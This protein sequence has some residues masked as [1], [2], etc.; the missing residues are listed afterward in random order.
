[1]VAEKMDGGLH[2]VGQRLNGRIRCRTDIEFRETDARIGGDIELYAV[3]AVD[4][5]ACEILRRGQRQRRE[6]SQADDLHVRMAHGAAGIRS[7]VFEEQSGFVLLAAAHSEPMLEPKAQQ[8]VKM[9]LV[10]MREGA[11]AIGCFYQDGL[12]RV[13]QDIVFVFDEQELAFLIDNAAKRRAVAKRTG[14][15]VVEDCFGL[16]PA[17]AYIERQ[18]ICRHAVTFLFLSYT[19]LVL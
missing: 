9:R 12:K 6:V 10:V 11:V 13:G 15:V 8:G 19:R 17:D 1:M 7:V 2:I 16:F 18:V 4:A 3:S 14:G 5:Q